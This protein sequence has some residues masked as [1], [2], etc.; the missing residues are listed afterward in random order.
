MVDRREQAAL[1]VALRNSELSWP[2]ISRRVEE[3]GSTSA[4]LEQLTSPSAPTLD[5]QPLDLDAE[6]ATMRTEIEQWSADGIGLVTLL[7]ETYPTQ[8][9]MVHQRPPFLT[10]RGLPD[11]AEMNA[12]AVVGSRAATPAGLE[13]ARTVATLLCN[14]GITVVSGLAAGIDTAAHQA[15]LDAGSRTVAVVGTGLRH[16]YPVENRDLQSRIAR[17]G[18]VFSQFW[19]DAG[20]AKRQFPMR[21]GVMSGLTVATVIVEAGEH[22]GARTQ[23]RLALEHGRHVFLMREVLV[24]EWARGIADRPNTTV[25]EGPD[26]VIKV[27]G[28]MLAETPDLIN[29]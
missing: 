16:C 25:L 6:I 13:R 26:H 22:S 17:T 27:L 11:P 29:L 3:V 23:A 24:N 19:P 20:P 4:I 28:D 12:V 10:Y 9:L 15:A 14:H 7:D 5:H 8:L 2:E 21:N 1:L 18:A